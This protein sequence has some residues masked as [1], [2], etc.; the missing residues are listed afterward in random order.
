MVMGAEAENLNTAIV[1]LS[2]VAAL[3]LAG[4]GLYFAYTAGYLRQA[5]DRF[6]EW[7]AS[8]TERAEIRAEQWRQVEEQRRNGVEV[9]LPSEFVVDRAVEAMVRSGFSLESRTATSAGFVKEKGAN[10]CLGCFLML[11][12]FPG[13]LYLLLARKTLRVTIAAYPQQ[14]GCRAVVGG[15]DPAGAARLVDWARGLAAD[16]RSLGEP[17]EPTGQAQESSGSFSERLRELAELRD[18]GLLTSEEFEAKK[19]DLLDRM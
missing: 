6:V 4:V 11:F 5:W 3:I 13:L 17:P 8:R 7:N 14:S 15:D 1:G 9:A 18:S 16:P 10:G 19:R 2:L 12:F